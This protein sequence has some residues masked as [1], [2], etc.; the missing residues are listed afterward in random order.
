MTYAPHADYELNRAAA[1]TRRDGRTRWVDAAGRI[2]AHRP[3]DRDAVRVSLRAAAA[4]Y[5]F[6]HATRA[7]R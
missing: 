6:Q 4:V 2:H 3:A 7:P 1:L 5:T